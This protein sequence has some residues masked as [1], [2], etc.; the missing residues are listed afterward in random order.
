MVLADGCIADQVDEILLRSFG[1]LVSC[2][3]NIYSS[4]RVI[5]INNFILF[6]FCF[7]FSK[8]NYCGEL[9]YEEKIEGY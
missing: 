7:L 3:G 1:L 2:L 9:N 6:Y 8:L 4:T 5:I